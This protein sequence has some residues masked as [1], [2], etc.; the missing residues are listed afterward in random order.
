MIHNELS[1]FAKIDSSKG[2]S[3]GGVIDLTGDEDPTDEDGDAEMDDSI[4]VLASL[5][6]NIVMENNII[7]K[8][9]IIT[10]LNSIEPG[11]FTRRR[12]KVMARKAIGGKEVARC[13][14]FGHKS[15]V[16]EVLRMISST[17]SSKPLSRN[18]K[19]KNSPY[20]IS[21]SHRAKG[22][23]SFVKC[24]MTRNDFI[25]VQVKA[26]TSTMIVKVIRVLK[27]VNV[28]GLEHLVDRLIF[29]QKGKRPHTDEA[30]GSDL[31]GDLYFVTWDDHL[32]PPSKQSWLPMEYT[33]AEA[34][35]LPHKRARLEF[36][37]VCT[38]RSPQSANDLKHNGR[39]T[40]I[41]KARLLLWTKAPMRMCSDTKRLGKKM[42]NL[43]PD[44]A[45][46]GAPFKSYE[47]LH[48]LHKT[49]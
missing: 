4:G 36:V 15:E 20:G 25:G 31:D 34:K 43:A 48:H 41:E 44:V 27:V 39:T 22:K 32:I 35:E 40:F 8:Y 21:W 2:L 19:A 5:E 12:W 14:V 17:Y 42:C 6:N 26:S 10:F 13:V 33:I 16:E 46:F 47:N 45:W 28:L 38:L 1:N 23:D 24:D 11:A 30:S 18:C 29:P 7:M 9:N 3:G 37:L 49:L